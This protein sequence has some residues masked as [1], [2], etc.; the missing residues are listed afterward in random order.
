MVEAAH[1]IRQAVARVTAMRLKTHTDAPL[2]AATVAVKRFQAR[3][4]RATYTDLFQSAEYAAAT[5]FFL[6]ELYSD[7]DFSLR[8]AQF[9]RIAGA[10]QRFFPASVVAT[11]VAMAELHALT[12]ELDLAMAEAWLADRDTAAGADSMR[13]TLAWQRVGRLTDREHQ[14]TAVLAV[15]TELDRLT[16]MPGLRMMLKMMRRPAHA[17]GLG[18]LQSFLEAGFDTFAAMSGNGRHAQ[19][20]LKLIE[21][22]ETHWIQQLFADDVQAT[23]HLLANALASEANANFHTR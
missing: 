6:D 13:Y 10:L 15:G 16:R 17:A 3:R 22:R 2:L 18:S 23:Q 20:F 14:L 5:R 8:D 1:T 7:K 21:T 4:F 11:A 9:A 19:Q 12:E